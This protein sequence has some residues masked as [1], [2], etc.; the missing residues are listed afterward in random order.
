VL[1]GKVFHHLSHA[2]SPFLYY[3][4]PHP[5]AGDLAQW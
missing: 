1:A 2:S 5:R 3:F 4:K